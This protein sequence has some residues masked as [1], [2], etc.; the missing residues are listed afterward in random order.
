VGYTLI[1]ASAPS[2]NTPTGQF[3][4]LQFGVTYINQT[5]FS[6]QQNPTRLWGSYSGIDMQ[7]GSMRIW[8][9]VGYAQNPLQAPELG[10][11]P[12][13]GASPIS[14]AGVW[15]SQFA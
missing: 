12:D 15:L 9:A 5:V 10:T 13:C 14:N 6:P 4:L 7:P 1:P 3:N 11:C 2:T 8:S